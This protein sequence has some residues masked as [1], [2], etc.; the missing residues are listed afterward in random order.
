MNHLAV[1]QAFQFE[2]RGDIRTFRDMRKHPAAPIPWEYCYFAG[3]R[4]ITAN[5][6]RYHHAMMIAD[7]HAA[8]LAALSAES[9]CLVDHVTVRSRHDVSLVFL[10]N[11]VMHDPSLPYAAQNYEAA[12]DQVRPLIGN[13]DGRY[14]LIGVTARHGFHIFN[15]EADTALH[16][17]DEANVQVLE[18]YG[19]SFRSLLVCQAH[20]VTLEF[21]ALVEQAV[22]RCKLLL[23]AMSAEPASVH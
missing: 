1:T 22:E 15:E 10:H 11:L 23:G 21:Y 3:F 8:F 17:I 20:P 13:F 12:V 5:G 7:S 2:H 18:Q 14:V 19:A 6:D 16:A 9:Q 4:V